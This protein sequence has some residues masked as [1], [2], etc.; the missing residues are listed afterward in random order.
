M[1]GAS[2]ACIPITG[3]R[4]WRSNF[5]V[6]YAEV[7]PP[8]ANSNCSAASFLADTCSALNTQW[9]RGDLL[10][11]AANLIWSPTKNFDIGLDVE[12]L[13][14]DSTLQ[15]PSASYI[16]AGKPGLHPDRLVDPTSG[17]SGSSEPP[18]SREC[19]NST[20]GFVGPPVSFLSKPSP[21]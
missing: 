10:Q 11:L 3:R 15:N 20:G 21:G 12:Y 16:A 5:A 7:T 1:T 14:L 4:E 18:R 6:G 9:G 13:H 19:L 2:T 8:T 17:S